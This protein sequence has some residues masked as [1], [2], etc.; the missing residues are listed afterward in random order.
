VGERS[1]DINFT[2]ICIYS[3]GKVTILDDGKKALALLKLQ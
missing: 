1:K 2:G 3:T